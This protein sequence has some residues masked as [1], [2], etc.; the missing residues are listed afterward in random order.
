MKLHVHRSMKVTLKLVFVLLIENYANIET[1]Q[2][3][4]IRYTSWD[5]FK[6]ARIID[7][8]SWQLICCTDEVL[9]YNTR[10]NIIG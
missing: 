4:Y 8:L 7:I 2:W 9:K 6:T 5:L 3:K 10:D 1:V